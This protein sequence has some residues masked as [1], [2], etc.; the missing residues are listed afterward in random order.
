MFVL[1]VMMTLD[2]F[3]QQAELVIL[4]MGPDDPY[5]TIER[6]MRSCREVGYRYHILLADQ[7]PPIA[8]AWRCSPIFVPGTTAYREHR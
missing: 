4:G 1:G 3:H 8:F 5:I 7:D 6:N 2:L